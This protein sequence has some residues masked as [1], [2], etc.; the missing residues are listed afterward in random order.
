MKAYLDT[1]ILRQLKKIPE[2]SEIE[3]VCSQ[4]GIMEIISGMTSEREYN[5]RRAA[6]SNILTR[7]VS[8]IWESTLTMQSKAFALNYSDYDVPA[9]QMLMNEIIKTESFSEAEKI[10]ISLGGNA[11]TIDTFTQHDKALVD[12]SVAT[13]RMTL[14]T[15]KDDRKFLRDN[16]YTPAIIRVQSE[17]TIVSFLNSLGIEKF[18][19]QYMDS[20]KHYS[21]FKP[22]TNYLYALTAYTFDAMANGNQ[23]GENDGHDIAHLVYADGVDLFISNDRIYQR[24]QKDLFTVDFLKLEEFIEKYFTE[25]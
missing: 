24:L 6:L 2:T 22:L 23:P 7:N 14:S 12:D 19:P 5:I 4:L 15:Q 1:N 16:P 9:T 18:T 10:S 8:I 20:I 11:Y 17:M 3:L 21:K 13:F 25:K